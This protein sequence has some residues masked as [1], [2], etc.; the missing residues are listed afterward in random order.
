MKVLP[1]RGICTEVLEIGQEDAHSFFEGM[2][3]ASLAEKAG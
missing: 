3:G 2:A 1:G